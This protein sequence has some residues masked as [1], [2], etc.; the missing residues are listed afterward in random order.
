MHTFLLTKAQWF[1][2]QDFL[3]DQ[4]LITNHLCWLYMDYISLHGAQC[5][6]VCMAQLNATTTLWWEQT[7]AAQWPDQSQRMFAMALVY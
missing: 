3:V 7:E 5:T 1:V 2:K 6:L 4:K